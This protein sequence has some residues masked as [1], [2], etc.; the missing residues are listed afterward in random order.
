MNK[1]DLIRAV[2]TDLGTTQKTAEDA[3]NSVIAHIK[4]ALNMGD[5]VA[6]H[7]LGKFT[8]KVAAAREGRNPKTG[9][10]IQIATKRSVKFKATKGFV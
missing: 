10:P 7:G 9:E 3:V 4:G 5:E 6:I 2:A 8:L 1:S